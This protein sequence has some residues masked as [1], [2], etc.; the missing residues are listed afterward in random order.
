MPYEIKKVSP[1]CW[2][3]VNK[4]TGAVKAKCTTEA[5]A[6]A[7]MRLLY[8]LESGKWKPTRPANSYRSF[9]SAEFKKRPAGTPASAWMKEIA[10]KWKAQKK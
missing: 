4:D 1:Q 9:V 7:Q 8:G 2:Q 6:K 5:K 10:A 3:V